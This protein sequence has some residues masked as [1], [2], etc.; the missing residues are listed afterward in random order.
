LM[1]NK[2]NEVFKDEVT[3]V[4]TSLVLDHQK[5]VTTTKRKPGLRRTSTR[6]C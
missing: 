3:E 2:S 1:Q 5:V 6:Y 4:K